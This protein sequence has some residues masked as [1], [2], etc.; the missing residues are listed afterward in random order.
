MPDP[1]LRPRE[2]LH[3]VEQK[4]L[5]YVPYVSAGVGDESLHSCSFPLWRNA[6]SGYVAGGG[7]RFGGVEE[8]AISAILGV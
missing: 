3:C 2:W 8:D 5:P 6:S 7:Q 4:C 1:V